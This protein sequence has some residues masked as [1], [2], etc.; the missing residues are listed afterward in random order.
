LAPGSSDAGT[1]TGTVR[2]TDNGVPPLSDTKSF[3][4]TV[5]NANSAPTA[6]ADGPYSGGVGANISFDGTG[7]SDPDGDVLTFAWDFGDGGTGTGATPVH[8]YATDGVFNVSL[9][10]TDPDGLYDD[11]TTTATIRA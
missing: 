6:D 11:D 7:S 4:I 9:R 2:V 8:A 5:L 3:Q 10:V 1:Y